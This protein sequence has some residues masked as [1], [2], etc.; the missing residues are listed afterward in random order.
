MDSMDANV[1]ATN[2]TAEAE[3]LPDGLVA[4]TADESINKSA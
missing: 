2:E 1:V 3:Q 4:E